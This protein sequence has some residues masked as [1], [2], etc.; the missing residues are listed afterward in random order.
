VTAYIDALRICS[1][2]TEALSCGN[3]EY[4]RGQLELLADLFPRPG[5]ERGDRCGEIATDIYEL[6]RIDRP[7]MSPTD[8]QLDELPEPILRSSEQRRRERA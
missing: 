2:D 3:D 6:A 1:A 8:E 5:V 4:Q 7:Q